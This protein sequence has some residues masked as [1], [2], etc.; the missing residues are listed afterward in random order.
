MHWAALSPNVYETEFSLL[1][2]AILDSDGRKKAE[3]A[4]FIL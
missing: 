3:P 4:P 2:L 1:Q